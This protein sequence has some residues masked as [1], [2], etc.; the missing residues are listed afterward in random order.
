MRYEKAA[1]NDFVYSKFINWAFQ[2]ILTAYKRL[3]N[4]FCFPLFFLIL[5][6]L[7]PFMILVTM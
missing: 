2:N 3:K 5:S 6:H 4:F 1:N 7:G